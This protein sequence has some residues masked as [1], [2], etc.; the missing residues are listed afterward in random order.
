MNAADVDD[1]AC[2]ENLH[3]QRLSTAGIMNARKSNG[4]VRYLA[5][6][7][8]RL[9]LNEVHDRPGYDSGSQEGSTH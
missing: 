7:G 4:Q 6:I 5:R 9:V 2:L 3:T 8:H 1:V